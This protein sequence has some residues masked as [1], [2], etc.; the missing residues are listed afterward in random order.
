MQTATSERWTAW[1]EREPTQ[2]RPR[3]RVKVRE[4]RT[5]QVPEGM[6][7]LELDLT[8]GSARE[9]VWTLIELLEPAP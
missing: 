1:E 3:V 7:P 9:L 2:G 6:S 4:K 5:R 8:R